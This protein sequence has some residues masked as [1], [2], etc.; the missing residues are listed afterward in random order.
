MEENHQRYYGGEGLQHDT[1]HQPLSHYQQHLIYQP[2]GYTSQQHEQHHRQQHG[3][4]HEQQHPATFVDATSSQA[5]MQTFQAGQMS[6]ASQ[7]AEKGW[8]HSMS[9][10]LPVIPSSVA[11]ATTPTTMQTPTSASQP[12]QQRPSGILKQELPANNQAS[13]ASQVSTG[14]SSHGPSRKIQTQM[15]FDRTGLGQQGAG[16]STARTNDGLP[17]DS[18]RMRNS[19]ASKGLGQTKPLSSKGDTVLI[20]SSGIID[21][22][23]KHLGKDEGSARGRIMESNKRPETLSRD[24]GRTKLPP[25]SQEK[26]IIRYKK[27]CGSGLV[28]NIHQGSKSESVRKS[29]I[30]TVTNRTI[31]TQKTRTLAMVRDRT[32]NGQ[33]IRPLAMAPDRTVYG[34]KIW[35]AAQRRRSNVKPVKRQRE[36]LIEKGVE[37]W[38]RYASSQQGDEDEWVEDGEWYDEEE[39]EEK[40][41]RDKEEREEEEEDDSDGDDDDDDDSLESDISELE[42]GEDYNN[43][44]EEE[45]KQEEND[46][47]AD[48]DDS[49]QEWDD[50]EMETE[51]EEE[52]D[53]D[54]PPLPE[55]FWYKFS[56]SRRDEDQKIVGVTA[57]EEIPAGKQYGPLEGELVGE[58]EG[59]LSQ[60]SWELCTKSNVLLYIDGGSDWL[61]HIQCTQR[62]AE[63]NMEAI[64]LYG[65]IYYRTTKCIEPGSELR[66]FYSKEYSNHVG[67]DT[68]LGKLTFHSELNAF[69]CPRCDIHY[70]DPKLMLRHIKL[71]HQGKSSTDLRPVVTFETRSKTSESKQSLEKALREEGK[72]FRRAT[73][74]LKPVANHRTEQERRNSSEIP[75]S[76][77]H[78]PPSTS[79]MPSSTNH[80]PSSTSHIPSSTSHNP[81]STSHNPSSTSHN[82]SST[83]HNPPSTSHNPSST[84]HN[85]PST[86]HIPPSTSHKTHRQTL[87]GKE[88]SKSSRELNKNIESRTH[89]VKP[90]VKPAT[91]SGKDL[92]CVTCCKTFTTE[93]RLQAHMMFH[94][95]T[96]KHNCPICGETQSSK[97]KLVRHMASHQRMIYQCQQC[98]KTYFSPKSLYCHEQKIHRKADKYYTCSM[99][100]LQF[101]WKHGMREHEKEHERNQERAPQRELTIQ[102]LVNPENRTTHKR[103]KLNKVNKP[104]RVIRNMDVVH[105][106]NGDTSNKDMLGKKPDY[107]QDPS[108]R[109]K[110]KYC[111]KRYTSV[112]CVKT[113]EREIHEGRGRYKC[114]YCP[115]QFVDRCRYEIHQQKHNVTDKLYKCTECPRS[116]ASEN[117]LKNH[118]GEHTGLKPFKC[119]VCGKGFGRKEL[120]K[121]HVGRV[122]SVVELKFP[123]SFCNKR[124]A[125][126]WDMK[127]HALRHTG[128]RPHECGICGKGFTAK[129]SLQLHVRAVHEKLKPYECDICGKRSSV[130]H[131]HNVHVLMHKKKGQHKPIGEEN[132]R[133]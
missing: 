25:A 28:Q 9:P 55:G 67:F 109:F 14:W 15:A 82:P 129:H 19:G 8:Q 132:K 51:D 39:E 12:P 29:G 36:E 73:Q 32:S 79:H 50:D 40:E 27:K 108:L 84:S 106:D 76:T 3:Q 80:I 49:Y 64:Q 127:K 98:P 116:F 60:S 23:T 62:Q 74:P 18:S 133:L 122:H 90:D 59:C 86:S 115:K 66:V 7:L 46:E 45:V 107:F 26:K 103:I 104:R 92:V 4:Q 5:T 42:T 95:F 52:E 118:H 96:T 100:P 1:T 123:C 97:H 101:R 30:A 48:E 44:Y 88:S 77:S 111:P 75:P 120:V 11:P 54:V 69:S 85:P 93:G 35:T 87:E 113:H 114:L 47:D 53:L 20:L 131:H 33:N 83:S 117:A 22:I 37:D 89:E 121:A 112:S 6:F 58:D 24:P 41:R 70:T 125:K 99:C 124:F 21:D 72:M 63:Q 57:E 16:Q 38:S 56:S 128:I 31:G 61:S 130:S 10:S 65:N 17:Q 94:T 78:I 102:E 110:C 68:D 13:S 81:S 71:S 2:T 119:D 105:E 43:D 91:K 34:Q 126:Q